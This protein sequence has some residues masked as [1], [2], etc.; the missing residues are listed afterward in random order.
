MTVIAWDGTT[1]AA[2]KQATIDGRASITTKIRR[3]GS[4]LVAFCGDAGRS[5]AMLRWYKDGAQADAF[6]DFQTKEE[7]MVGFVVVKSTGRVIKFDNSP[8]PIEFEDTVYAM[9]CGRD[10]AL[11]A[12][13]L[14]K[15]AREAVEVA[16]ALDVF[17]GQG[18]DTLTLEA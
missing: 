15:T 4:D 12:M 9:G 10:Y 2:D 3:V 8:E 1:L 14:G 18:I 5:R 16:C 13:H 7:S 11:A 17:C 6:P